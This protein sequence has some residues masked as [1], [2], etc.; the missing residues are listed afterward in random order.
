MVKVDLDKCVGCGFCQISCPR[1]ALR[2][3]GHV[4]VDLNRCEDCYGGIYRFG[5]NAPLKDKHAVL[6]ARIRWQRA[7]I[8]NCPVKAL[9]A[10]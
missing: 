7:C 9:S 10:D 3:W 2:I 1:E 8:I 6:E 4:N 5:E